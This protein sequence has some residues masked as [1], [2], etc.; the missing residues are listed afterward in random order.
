MS[1]NSISKNLNRTLVLASRSPRRK[2][3]LEKA[4][5]K[6]TPFSVEVSENLSENLNLDDAIMEIARRKAVAILEPVKSLNLQNILVLSSDTLVVL[7]GEVLG[8][9][10]DEGQAYDFLRRLSG[11][12]HEVKT[13]ICFYDTVTGNVI[14]QIESSF[15]TF[16]NL[17]DD[18]IWSY[19]KSGDPMDKAGAYGIQGPGGKFISHLDGEL[20]NVMGLP[21]KRVLKI[22]QENGWEIKRL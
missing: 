1:T 22:I 13:S 2:E 4:G 19:I 12:T 7:M 6:H 8:K 20:E 15:V 5:I 17:T 16:R 10:I 11:Q 14:S 21:I 3:L 9:P 18:E